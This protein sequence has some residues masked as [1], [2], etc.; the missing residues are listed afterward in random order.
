MR[1][2][3]IPVRPALRIRPEPSFLRRK[4]PYHVSTSDSRR[5]SHCDT[6]FDHRGA[7]EAIEFYKRAFGAVE[8]LRLAAPDGKIAHAEVKIGDSPIMLAE[9]V[10]EMN[11]RSPN[12]YGGS[13]VS[14]C[15]Y[16][17]DADA[18]FNQAIGAGAKEVRPLVDQFYGDRSGTL[19]DP[20]GHV[21]TISTHIEDVPEDEI[22]RRFAEM[23]SQ[24]GGE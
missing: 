19:E 4:A 23:M 13:P 5:L 6:L 2:A 10:A 18:L 7:A 24:Q 8:L 9:A 17:E 11:I 16:V 20:Y 14:I 22:T 12:A 1:V 15:L 21:W 3:A